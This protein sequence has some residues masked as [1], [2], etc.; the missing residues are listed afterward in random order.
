MIRAH[1]N[2]ALIKYWGKLNDELRLPYQ[3]SLSFTVDNLYTDTNV[4]Y[5]DNLT[6]DIVTINGVTN[7]PI[8]SKRVTKYMD[9]LR[10]ELNFNKYADITSTNYVPTAAGLA[11][12]ASAFAALSV[13]AVKGLNLDLS[14]SELSRLARLGSGSASRSIFGGFSVW[15]TGDDKTSV[16]TPLNINWPEFRIIVC[17]VDTNVKSHSSSV[18]MKESV[19]NKE[20]YNVWVKESKI[21]LDNMYQALDKKDIDLVGSIAEK[22]ANHMHDL[23]ESTGITY[24]TKE[25]HDV[26]DKIHNMRQQGIK[27]YY[28]MDA[29]PNV[30]IITVANQV[31][32]ILEKLGNIETLVC[33]QGPGVT[34]I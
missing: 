32:L 18:A 15:N 29:G 6:N 5:D 22:N 10:K 14:N 19:Q 11:S 33:K 7:D 9:L 21:D 31:D 30:K 1:V 4:V 27:A 25:S 12:S 8:M 17:F 16:A 23:V 26:I 13:A 28:T 2:F 24:K 34:I 3:A 20:L